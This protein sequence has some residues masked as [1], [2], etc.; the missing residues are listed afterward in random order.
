MQYSE[1][2]KIILELSLFYSIAA[3]KLLHHSSIEF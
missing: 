2:L 3:W 1:F